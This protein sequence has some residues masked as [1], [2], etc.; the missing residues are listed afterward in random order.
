MLY[1][2]C[3]ESEVLLI[4]FSDFTGSVRHINVTINPGFSKREKYNTMLSQYLAILKCIK[5]CVL[6]VV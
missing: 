5:K 3:F 1:F 6:A 4:S 2:I